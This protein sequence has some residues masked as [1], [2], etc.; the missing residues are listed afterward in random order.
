MSTKLCRFLKSD[1]ESAFPQRA[2]VLR[3]FWALFYADGWRAVVLFRLSVMLAG[4]GYVRLARMVASWNLILTGADMSPL[5]RIGQG[6]HV[7]HPVGVV[8]GDGFVA[9]E[10]L[11][12]LQGVTLGENYKFSDKGL[13]PEV[14]NRVTVCSNAVVVGPI[15]LGDDIVIGANSFVSKSLEGGRVYAGIPAVEVG[16]HQSTDAYWR[17]KRAVG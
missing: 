9:G 4:R 11:T 5:G 10:G 12:L 2:T 7:K 17:F 1:F 14:G 16:K 15:V 3:G 6:F 8:V 13:Y